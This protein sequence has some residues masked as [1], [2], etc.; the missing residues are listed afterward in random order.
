MLVYF[1]LIA[2]WVGEKDTA[3]QYLAAN[4][5][6]PGGY[7]VATYGALKLLLL[8]DPLRGDPRFE[9]IV[10]SLAPKDSSKK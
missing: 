6:S 9:A 10:V 3:L 2:A 4:A 7:A 5:Q 8:W 1:V